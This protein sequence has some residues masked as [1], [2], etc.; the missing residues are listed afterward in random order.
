MLVS[1]FLKMIT[2]NHLPYIHKP[3]G[4]F[5]NNSLNKSCVFRWKFQFEPRYI[6]IIL[7]IVNDHLIERRHVL[8]ETDNKLM[9]GWWNLSPMHYAVSKKLKLTNLNSLNIIPALHLMISRTMSGGRVARLRSAYE[10]DLLDVQ[11]HENIFSNRREPLVT[12]I[13]RNS[14]NISLAP[15]SSSLACDF[16][17]TQARSLPPIS[18]AYTC[19]EDNS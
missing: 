13:S 15:L 10:R 16:S 9:P 1:I 5:W 12:S 11:S 19:F 4:I 3:I 18:L 2:N 17:T 8:E 6:H 14:R 7:I